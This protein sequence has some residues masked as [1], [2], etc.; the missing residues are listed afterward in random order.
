MQPCEELKNI[1]LQHYGK[2]HAREQAQSLE[3]TYSRQEGVVSISNDLN[4]WLDH[5]DSIEAFIKACGTSQQDIE[6]QNLV[7]YCEGSVGWT[8][9]WVTVMLPNGIQIPVRL[10][11]IFHQEEGALKMVHMHVSVAIPDEK[12]D[13]VYS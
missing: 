9:D 1:V 8:A 5:H 11:R 10:T 4:E 7:A 3:E 6:V 12:I 13:L 2:F